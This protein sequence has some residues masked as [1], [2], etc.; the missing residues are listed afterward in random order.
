MLNEELHMNE[1]GG[2]CS[3]EN[4][5]NVHNN[6]NGDGGQLREKDNEQNRALCNG[7]L[8]LVLGAVGKGGEG[9]VHRRRR[10]TDTDRIRGIHP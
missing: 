9:E 4:L 2:C 7:S 8:C 5:G 6:N 3:N 1:H 10:P